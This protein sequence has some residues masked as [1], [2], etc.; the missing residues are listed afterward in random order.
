[1]PIPT[2]PPFKLSQVKAET[3]QASMAHAAVALG[4]G[5]LVGADLQPDIKCTSFAGKALGNFQ[6]TIARG[7]DSGAPGYTTYN[8]YETVYD[9]V[10]AGFYMI[11]AEKQP[12]NAY[13]S[14][15][16]TQ[17][18][19]AKTFSVYCYAN[20]KTYNYTKLQTDMYHVTGAPAQ[21]LF[22]LFAANNTRVLKF[23]I[24]HA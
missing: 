3:G 7:D 20:G 1:M 24:T 17:H 21:E 13:E 11:S 19:T 22:N 10:G 14:T 4:M 5:K 18:S 15:V 9:S 6:A 2:K 16:Y 8:S 23:R 12:A